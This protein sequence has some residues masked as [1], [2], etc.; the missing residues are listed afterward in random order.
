MLRRQGHVAEAADGAKAHVYLLLNS[1]S[2]ARDTAV[3]VRYESAVGSKINDRAVI[4]PIRID[5][6]PLPAIIADLAQTPRVTP[7]VAYDNRDLAWATV[8]ADIRK[9]VESMLGIPPS[10]SQRR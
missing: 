3:R 4:V 7:V 6:T 2:F 10:A 8:A 9:L 1:G 5:H